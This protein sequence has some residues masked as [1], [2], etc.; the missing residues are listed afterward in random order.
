MEGFG[1]Q[2]CVIKRKRKAA[3]LNLAVVDLRE[4][5]KQVSGVQDH[6]A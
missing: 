2:V 3:F 1:E 5:T 4:A 6:V